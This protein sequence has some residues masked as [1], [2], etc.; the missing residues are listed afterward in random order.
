[1]DL[2]EFI[3]EH[4][5]AL[6]H[7]WAGYA[8][9]ISQE[10]TRLSEKQL[11]NSAGDILAA[12]S[13][14]MR[15]SQSPAEQTAKSRGEGSEQESQFTRVARLHAEDR[16]SHGFG[17]NDVVAEFR[18]LRAT[19]LR[20]WET[21]SPR[22]A[23]AFQQM[24][25]FNEAID[26]VLAESIRHYAEHTEHGRDLFTAVLA[27]DLRSPL[28]AILNASQA[29]HYDAQLSP[30]SVRSL[31]FVQRSAKRMN[32]MI[33]D[34][35]AF[36]R[37]RLGDTLP[38]SIAQHDITQIIRDAVSEVNASYPNAHIELRCAD[39]LP[40]NCD[41]GR[42]CQLIV[43]LLTNAA[44]YGSGRIAI[45]AIGD[46]DE[47]TVSVFNEGK[48]I[49]EEAFPTLFDPLTRGTRS[50]ENGPSTGMGLGLYICRCIANAHHGTIKVLSG[51]RGTTFTLRMPRL[52]Q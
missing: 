3:A 37:T 36:T 25:R 2:S 15:T 20:Y 11:R 16:L 24:I 39:G 44:R 38:V 48:P 19:V 49:P 13:A 51:E 31:D 4:R 30:A 46:T 9:K 7:A 41:A 52:P 42:I 26:Q 43:N 32:E 50:D 29:L 6:V 40:V 5:E 21:T 8:L 33:D 47:I 35:L 22:G 1:M 27:H 12:I 45:E 23:A 10:D 17:I 18:A 14:D 34:M 28:G